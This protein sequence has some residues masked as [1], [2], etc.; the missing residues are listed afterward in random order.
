M[1]FRGDITTKSAEADIAAF[2]L[3]KFGTAD[4]SVVAATDGSA[5]IAGVN[6]ELDVKTGEPADI[7]RSGIPLVQ[8]GGTVTKGDPLTAGAD[9]KAVKAEPAAGAN[10]FIA[11][12][13]EVDG[14]DGDIGEYL[15]LPGV[16]QGA[17]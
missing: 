17:A 4:E 13:A 6:G 9:G 1:G 7:V 10:V 12:Y 16:L 3:T 8:F 14:V 11:G 2:R 15:A 5:F